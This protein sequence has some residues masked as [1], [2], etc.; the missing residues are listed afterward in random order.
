MSYYVLFLQIGRSKSKKKESS[1]EESDGAS[2]KDSERQRGG[3]KPAQ[4]KKTKT[5]SFISHTVQ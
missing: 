1:V 5:V 4:S 2:E 3:K